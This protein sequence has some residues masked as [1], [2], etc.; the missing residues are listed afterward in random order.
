MPSELRSGPQVERVLRKIEELLHKI[1]ST[2]EMMVKP[3]PS[4]DYSVL[5][6]HCADGSHTF[7]FILGRIKTKDTSFFRTEPEASV[8]LLKLLKAQ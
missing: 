8:E 3:A 4:A 1:P 2:G 5:K 7:E 6:L